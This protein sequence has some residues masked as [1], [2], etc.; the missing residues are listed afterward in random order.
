M[1]GKGRR[2]EGIKE[3]EG[4]GIRVPDKLSKTKYRI[5][6][7]HANIESRISKSQNID[8]QKIECKISI[9]KISNAKYGSDKK[10]NA[11]YSRGKISKR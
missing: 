10:S 2:G 3:R 8:R 6:K 1:G 7:Y 9:G 11:N 4:Y 5:T